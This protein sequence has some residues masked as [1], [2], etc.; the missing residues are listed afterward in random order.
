MSGKIEFALSQEAFDRF[1]ARLDSD[2]ERAGQKYET[3]RRKLI[4]FFR[5]RDCPDDSALVD[6]TIDRVARKLGEEH[7]EKLMPY[8]LAVARRV[9]SEAW[10][11]E[12]VPRP[13]PPVPSQPPGW[14]QQLEFLSVCMQLLPARQRTLVLDYYQHDKS[15][16]IEDKRRLAADLGIAATAL[17]VRVFRIRRQLEQCVTNKIREA[18]GTGNGFENRSLKN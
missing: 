11:R 17:R 13:A 5:Y 12:D 4:M 18:V 1:L 6:E 16:K 10:R 2:R 9:A 7:I 15:Q 14:E 8:I 3:L